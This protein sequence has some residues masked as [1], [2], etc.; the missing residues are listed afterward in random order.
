ML[1]LLLGLA[2]LQQLRNSVPPGGVFQI[3]GPLIYDIWWTEE[4]EELREAK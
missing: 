3:T 2:V 1:A 4:R